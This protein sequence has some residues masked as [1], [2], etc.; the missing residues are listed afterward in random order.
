M[1]LRFRGVEHVRPQAFLTVVGA[2]DD[3]DAADSDPDGA[4]VCH[5][6][7]LSFSGLA[8]AGVCS[9]GSG[10]SW[11]WLPRLRPQ[12]AWA[13]GVVAWF[14]DTGG[15]FTGRSSVDVGAKP[16]P[17]SWGTTSVTDSTACPSA[18]LAGLMSSF[19]MLCLF[20]TRCSPFYVAANVTTRRASANSTLPSMRV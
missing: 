2:A 14:V 8:G 19:A 12:P 15:R 11:P 3:G 10:P 13:M 1:R 17:A 9:S 5:S 6:Y 16:A 20:P 7:L 4:A 18:G